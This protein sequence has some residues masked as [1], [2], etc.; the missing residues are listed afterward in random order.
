[1]ALP[2]MINCEFL[3]IFG[4]LVNQNLTSSGVMD[5]EVLYFS[6]KCY[7]LL[8][9]ENIL[10]LLKDFQTFSVYFTLKYVFLF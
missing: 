8:P 1:M 9:F 2:T 10:S 3:I 7:N 6:E 5:I 4:F